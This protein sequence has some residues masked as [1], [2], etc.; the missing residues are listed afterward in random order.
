MENGFGACF[1]EMNG[2]IRRTEFIVMG[3][4]IM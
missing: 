2:E 1:L 3:D 4:A